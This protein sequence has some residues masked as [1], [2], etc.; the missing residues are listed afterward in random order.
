MRISV[1]VIIVVLLVLAAC[2]LRPYAQVAARK[3]G[4]DVYWVYELPGFLT[5]TEC[6]QLKAA[7][8]H[9]SFDT[10]HVYKDGDHVFDEG[11]RKSRTTW[12]KHNH[13]ISDKIASTVARLLD[14][15]RSHL[16]DLQVV[17]YPAGGYFRPHYDADLSQPDT[18]VASRQ[19]TVLVY[20]N[21]DYE[22]G[23]TT[24]PLINHTVKPEKGKAVVFWTLDVQ[25]Q[26]VPQALHGGDPVRSGT[27]WICNQWVHTKAIGS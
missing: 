15:P 24:F 23:G 1:V 20:L 25:H 12:L 13:A 11:A 5:D 6:E 16:E 10:S 2:M 27:K 22:G 7:A 8:S 3:V 17:Q 19:A 14:A 9:Q 26:I 21:D 4:T 18:Q